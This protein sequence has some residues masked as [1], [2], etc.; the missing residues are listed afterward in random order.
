[1]GKFA[2][3]AREAQGDWA[4]FKD[5]LK[6]QEIVVFDFETTGFKAKDGN[7]PIQIAGVKIVDG[8]IVDRFN[9][10]MNPGRSIKDTFAA[11]SGKDADGNLLTDEWLAQ[12]PS[13]AEALQKFLDWAG[14]NPLVVAQ[15]A[16]FDDEVMKR[17]AG[18]L[19]LEWNPAGMADTR[20]MAAAIF[21][22]AP[23]NPGGNDLD[24]IANYFGINNENWHDGAND[25]EV[26]AQAFNALIEKGI[27]DKFGV[28]ALDA[29]AQQAEFDAAMEKVA[30][31]L[32][33]YNQKRA[34]YL[35]EIALRDGLAGRPVN[36]EE[37]S[38]QIPEG[39]LVQG[40]IDNIGAMGNPEPVDEPRPDLVS[41]EID[42]VFPDGKMRIAPAEFVEDL[43][44]FEQIFRGGIKA[45][46]VR[47]GDFMRPKKDDDGEF[48][49]VVS[50]RGG[51]DYGLDE[52][53]R[54]FVLQ[55]AEGERRVAV[56]NQNAFID[57]VRRPKNR[58]ELAGEPMP[59]PERTPEEMNMQAV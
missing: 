45:D 9:I 33:E 10:Y 7:E 12:Q 22:D 14:P 35:A 28:N 58:A 32:E 17:K 11:K 26:T 30:P 47:P 40:P 8:K 56:M 37:L 27:Q 55:N 48:F 24:R 52:W 1:M 50:I 4:A 3:W 54:R 46:Q 38:K 53:K 25:A 36:L 42:S 15:N 2:D 31:R 41:V 21:K 44:N 39:G 6:G 51:E 20:G 29:D 59:Q 18:E 5:K 34:Q 16:A 43:N 13:Q 23:D 57:E 49:L 19:G